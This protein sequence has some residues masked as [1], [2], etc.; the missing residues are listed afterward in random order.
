MAGRYQDYYTQFAAACRGEAE[1]PVSGEEGLRTV[2][3]LDA[4]RES[5]ATGR[6]VVLG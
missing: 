6:T 3:V 4:A 5:A 1:V 2:E